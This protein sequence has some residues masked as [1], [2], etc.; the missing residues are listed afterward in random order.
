M[1][2]TDLGLIEQPPNESLVHQLEG[3]VTAAK[4]GD[5]QEIAYV[6]SYRGNFVNHG[7]SRITNRMRIIGELEQIKWH[8]LS[9]DK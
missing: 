8:L 6:C 5:L 7:W 4:S 2:K 9:M 3:L 1:R